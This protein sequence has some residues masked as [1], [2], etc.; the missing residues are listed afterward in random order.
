MRVEESSYNSFL[1]NSSEAIIPDYERKGEWNASHFNIH[2]CVYIYI[3]GY[4]KQEK[5][6]YSRFQ[7]QLR[8]S[9]C[10]LTK[11]GCEQWVMNNVKAQSY[12]QSPG[13]AGSSPS[14][15]MDFENL[16]FSFS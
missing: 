8:A 3:Q 7:D 12:K 13:F 4:L 9:V 16:S 10:I 11:Q 14:G 15:E 6:Y 1:K 5:K 2:S